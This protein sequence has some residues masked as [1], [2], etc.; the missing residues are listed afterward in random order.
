MTKTINN[1]LSK[2]IDRSSNRFLA[3]KLLFIFGLSAAYILGFGLLY[4]QFGNGV[5]MLSLIP[6]LLIGLF[7]GQKFGI[8]SAVIY[9]C[10]NSTLFIY[11]GIATL[12]ETLT[13]GIAFGGFALLIMGAMMG[14]MSD[15]RYELSE[16]LK[17]KEKIK[18]ELE[19]Q[20]TRVQEILNEQE[21]LVCRF[22]PQLKITYINP[23][24]LKFLNCPMGDA[25]GT[26]LLEAFTDKE[27]KFIAKFFDKSVPRTKSIKFEYPLH[28]P[29]QEKVFFQWVITPIFDQE[30]TLSEFQAVGRDITGAAQTRE[31]EREQR[32][33]IE[34]LSNSAAVL[35]DTLNI[36]EVLIRV[37]ENIG[38]VVPHDA[39]NIMLIKNKAAKIMQLTGYEKFI[40][41]IDTF[42]NIEFPL[43]LPNFHQMLT[44]GKGVIISDT[45][46]DPRWEKMS[47]NNWIRAYLGAPLMFKDKLIG[48]L[49]L[50][51]AEKGFFQEKHVEWLQAFADQAVIAIK[52]AQLF[53]ETKERAKQLSLLNESTRIAIN[54]VSL[55]EVKQPMVKLIHQ[56]FNTDFVQISIWD[57]T[58]QNFNSYTE[59]TAEIKLQA[60]SNEDVHF[61]TQIAK[62]IMESG[63][64]KV[65]TDIP[66]NIELPPAFKEK[67]PLSTM[68]LLPLRVFEQKLGFIFLGYVN[69]IVILQ[70][71]LLLMEQF[72]RQ[73]ALAI[74]K[75]QMYINEKERRQKLSRTNQIL[76]TITEIGANVQLD[77][78]IQKLLYFI[79]E[80]LQTINLE[81]CFA[82]K[83]P[84]QQEFVVQ[85]SS[86]ENKAQSLPDKSDQD[87]FHLIKISDFPHFQDL[88]EKKQPIFLD[89]MTE[90]LRNLLPKSTALPD[91][92][93]EKINIHKDTC[94]LFM[95]II[96]NEQVTGIICIWGDEIQVDDQ[97]TLS[98][99]TIQVE[100]AIEKNKLYQKIQQLAITDSLTGFYN[101][102]GLEELGKHEIDRSMR[103]SRPLTGLM[104]DID[105]FKSV[106][107][108]FGHPVGDEILIQLAR[109]LQSKLR[110]VDIL[111][112]YGGEEFFIMLPETNYHDGFRIAE[113]LRSLV[114][115]YA[116]ATNIGLINITISI[117]ISYLSKNIFT[118]DDM[119]YSADQAL[120]EVKNN[121]RNSIQV[122]KLKTEKEA[123][124]EELK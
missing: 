81:C 8:L 21:D 69:K 54:A 77:L 104:I 39:A 32:Q 79:G 42:K 46:Q 19:S 35:N 117:G 111:S 78:N 12:K 7:F 37:L 118:L 40:K 31:K 110:E 62:S 16:E 61:Q 94:S 124:S 50:D 101:R 66:N 20:K 25:L 120:Y 115:N 38:K 113:R 85:Y 14:Y 90:V 112:R 9:Q 95:P 106:N 30:N 47:T 68:V 114:Q 24:G 15:L 23:T 108:T 11:Y 73:T 53:E 55:D 3:V 119:I 74:S 123:P 93:L 58:Q 49:N 92:Y 33:F 56:L 105:K 82:L 65:F 4:L 107:D 97:S 5:A 76:S 59:K 102:R 109:L 67:T 88:I 22:T 43:S 29:N 116:F 70:H 87:D 44:L 91:E 99:L 83:D 72:A 96:V 18:E 100:T 57:E 98:L 48:F 26:N 2:L 17:L 63:K 41:D 86:M 27:A 89:N 60:F 75:T 28:K 45:L 1:P 122:F 10:I 71:E 121:G 103:F 51:S 52:N 36:D 64:L 84:D 34:A 80:R 6:V 13:T